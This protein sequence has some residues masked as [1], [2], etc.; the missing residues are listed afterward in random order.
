[1]FFRNSVKKCYSVVK[2]YS[3]LSIPHF[4]DISE[5]TI[6]GNKMSTKRAGGTTHSV[7]DLF[8][9]VKRTEG[10]IMTCMYYENKISLMYI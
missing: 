1:M 8:P 9:K 7:A 10:N 4:A 2:Y 6:T 3:I 5:V